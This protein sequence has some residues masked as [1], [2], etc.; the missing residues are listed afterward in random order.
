MGFTADASTGPLDVAVIFGGPS[1]SHDISIVTGLTVC[2]ALGV[3]GDST[4]EPGQ[5]HGIYWAKNEQ[6]FLVDPEL[7]PAAFLEGPPAGA[8][9]LQFVAQPGGGFFM[10][11][12]G[13]L[14]SREHQ[15]RLATVV[16]CCHG[17]PGQDGTL[18]G[19]LDMAALVYTGPSGRSA[20]LCDDRL[21]LAALLGASGIPCVPRVPV[22]AGSGAPDWDGWTGP[23]LVRPRFS[24]EPM[25][26]EVVPQWA[27]VTRALELGSAHLAMG[28]VASPYRRESARASVALRSSPSLEVSAVAWSAPEGGG[29]TGTPPP[30]APGHVAA[31]LADAARAIAAL[32]EVRGVYQV[33]FVV[34]P[35]AGQWWVDGVDTA[36][37]GLAAGLWAASGVD[38]AA[39]V[40]DM[41]EE[42]GRR[43]TTQ[44]GSP[45][46]DGSALRAP[47]PPP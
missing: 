26:S 5:V 39:L 33:D 17:G 4:A 15:L 43:P 3:V 7:G 41:V 11:K 21:A 38:L 40:F 44:W 9:P 10:A 8:R 23:Y 32:V 18:Q 16:V 12:S 45:G 37:P 6:F 20:R 1:P 29:T 14:G 27:D 2:R 42:A 19:A 36:P 24:G 13:L 47:F 31:E 46:S 35:G 30:G 25:A 28:V 22:V 34:G